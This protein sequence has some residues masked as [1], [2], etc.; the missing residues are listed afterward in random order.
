MDYDLFLE[1]ALRN[2]EQAVRIMR[3][4]GFALGTA[5]GSF[6]DIGLR[7]LVRDRA[8]LVATTPQGLMV[9]LLLAVSGYPFAE[10]ARDAATVAVRGVPVK[11]G[12]LTKLLR[13]KQLAGRAKD[14]ACLR[15]YEAL[16]NDSS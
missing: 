13:S 12:R 11:V 7:R 1:P 3:R 9:E 6:R 8:T 2:V 14:R 5:A 10:L 4:L 16:L 15:R